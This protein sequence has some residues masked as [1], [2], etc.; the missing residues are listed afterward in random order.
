[1][2]S[3]MGTLVPFTNGYAM[4]H[5]TL[6]SNGIAAG[7]LKDTLSSFAQAI[8]KFQDEWFALTS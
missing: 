2:Y 8:D 6:V 1:M 5:E 3:F 7:N 4:K